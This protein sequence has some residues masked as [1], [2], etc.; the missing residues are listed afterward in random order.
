MLNYTIAQNS[1][2][3][4]SYCSHWLILFNITKWTVFW[5]ADD[6]LNHLRT[7]GTSESFLYWFCWLLCLML[8]Y[9]ILEILTPLLITKSSQNLKRN[10]TR[11]LSFVMAFYYMIYFYCHLL[12]VKIEENHWMRGKLWS[13]NHIFHHCQKRM[14]FWH[15][16]ACDCIWLYP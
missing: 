2:Y 8:F 10:I 4:N 5:C 7:E 11:T 12:S 16:I 13:K 3:T 14:N 6:L 1:M 15:R 9:V